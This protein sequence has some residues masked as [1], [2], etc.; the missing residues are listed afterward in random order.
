ME[1]FDCE[2]ESEVLA[3]VLQSRWPERA[4]AGLRAHA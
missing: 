4:D 2:F 3:A 1:R